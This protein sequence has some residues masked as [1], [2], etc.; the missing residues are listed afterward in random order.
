MRDEPLE[1]NRISLQNSSA[2]LFEAQ[3]QFDVSDN[4]ALQRFVKSGAELA[5]GKRLQYPW[6]NQYNARV[7]EGAQQILAGNQVHSGLSA[8]RGVDLG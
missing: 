8:N 6:I 5:I 2:I 4:A 7:M 3:K 1:F